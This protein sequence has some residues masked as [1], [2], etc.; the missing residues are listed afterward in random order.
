MESK[1]NNLDCFKCAL[2]FDEDH[3]IERGVTLPCG[4]LAC[5]NC[6]YLFKENTGY[7]EFKC[8]FC[9]VLNSL[10]VNYCE[11]ILLKSLVESNYKY[12][13]SDIKNQYEETFKRLKSI[14]V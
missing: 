11:S 3:F 14:I 6:L 4:H 13:L 2:S 7:V 10:E 12:L 1:I 9:E 5:S 8:G